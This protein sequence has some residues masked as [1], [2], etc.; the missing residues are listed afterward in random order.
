MA[1]KKEHF[2]QKFLSY[3][4]LIAALSL[5]SNS[6]CI[7][8][9]AQN[10]ND[11]KPV[12]IVIPE[13]VSTLETLTA[14]FYD[15]AAEKLRDLLFNSLVKKNDK[16]EYV[17]ELAENIKIENDNQTVIFTLRDGVKFH[18]GKLLTSTD[19]KYTL[20]AMFQSDSVKA[21]SFFELSEDKKN[22]S[23][24][25]KVSHIV[26]VNTPNKQTIIIKVSR[27]SL[28]N[29]L[30]SNLVTIPIIPEGTVEQQKTSPVGSGAF[31]FV[32]YDDLYG[33]IELEANSDYWEGEP[34]IKK[35]VIKTVID[36]NAL[37]AELLRGRV[38]IAPFV[39]NISADSLKNLGENENLRVEHFSGANIQ[40]LAFNTQS[41]F[42]N[43]AKIRQAVAYSIDREKI[44]KEIFGGRAKI[45]HSI[46]PEESWAYS[47]GTKYIYNPV[48]A[49]Q[50][51]KEAGYNGELIKFRVGYSGNPYILQYSQFI[52]KSL[53][54]IG[55]NAELETVEPSLLRETLK[56]GQFQIFTGAWI[57]GNQDP[58]F[59]KDLFA[60]SEI[61]EKKDGGRNRS[62]YSNAEFDRIID[63]VSNSVDKIKTKQLY[64]KAQEIVS[65]D[66]P[67]FTLWH[68][69][70]IVVSNK[71]IGNIKPKITGDWKFIKD[72]TIN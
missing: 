68:P 37:Q 62:R 31:K 63:E 61:P 54:E 18:N 7:E 1:Q 11:S 35:L 2:Y 45:A 66:L 27:S 12:V 57:G 50:L 71:R 48:K 56:T 28:V 13:K 23:Q 36:S 29:Q 46:L 72:L 33:D 20:D 24:S 14:K 32:N 51:L 65:R 40:Y 60:S 49:K 21:N 55:F 43:K 25:K 58:I 16:L 10:E 44:I 52:Q 47:S 59:L 70:N 8:I 53:K 19:V 67:L 3:I 22:S 42:F 38:D 30:L 26:S 4:L 64:T 34:Q 15:S 6:M 9:F 69:A 39:T 5:L 41:K 17:G